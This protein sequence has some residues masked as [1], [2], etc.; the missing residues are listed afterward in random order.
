MKNKFARKYFLALGR[1]VFPP[2]PC[3]SLPCIEGG[4]ENVVLGENNFSV[5]NAASSIAKEDGHET[6]GLGSGCV[7]CLERRP[8]T[9]PAFCLDTG[10]GDGRRG[11]PRGAGDRQFG[12]RPLHGPPGQPRQRCRGHG[13][14]PAELGLRGVASAEPE[15]RG[16]GKG[17]DGFHR[18]CPGQRRGPVLFRWP[19]GAGGPG[20]LPGAAGVA[21]VFPTRRQV[22]RRPRQLGGGSHEEQRRPGQYRDP[23]RLPQQPPPQ[24]Q[25]FGRA[26]SGR[27]AGRFRNPDRLRRR[28]G[29]GGRREPAWPQWALHGGIAEKPAPTGTIPRGGIPA[30]PERGV[31]P[32]RQPADTPGLEPV[33]GQHFPG[34]HPI[35]HETHREKCRPA[36]GQLRPPHD[37]QSRGGILEG[38]H[39]RQ[40]GG[41]LSGIS[42]RL[43][44][45]PLRPAGPPP[46]TPP[47]AQGE[48]AS[49]TGIS[50]AFETIPPRRQE[51]ARAPPR[52][53]LPGAPISSVAQ[54]HGPPSAH[55]AGAF[56]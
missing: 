14:D 5:E 20:Q 3:P 15:P 13:E 42:G 23:R 51:T 48:Q 4:G 16:H 21:N 31:S 47:V 18:L 40:Y 22:P 11:T 28:S 43:S 7:S 49:T 35:G 56:R 9:G 17:R 41:G 50:H 39:Q 26:R 12:L 24:N 37:P 53:P 10:P 2:G 38:R 27:D 29:T 19:W 36:Q 55:L 8:G 6:I 33:G 46:D 34:R 32:Q 45:R 30:H 52:P 1:I 25:A 54:N 44:K